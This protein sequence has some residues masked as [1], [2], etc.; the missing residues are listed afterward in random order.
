M[1]MSEL[2]TMDKRDLIKAFRDYQKEWL[3]SHH[4]FE[5]SPML[6]EVF[7]KFLDDTAERFMV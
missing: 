4:D 6:E 3:Y 1:R 5:L 2:I 7:A